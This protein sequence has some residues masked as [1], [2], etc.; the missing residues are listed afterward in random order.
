MSET[1]KGFV[2][3]SKTVLRRIYI[4]KSEHIGAAA[5]A[6][7]WANVEGGNIYGINYLDEVKPIVYKALLEFYALCIDLP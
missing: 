3:K 6:R 7:A 4:G 5:G 2:D 1:R